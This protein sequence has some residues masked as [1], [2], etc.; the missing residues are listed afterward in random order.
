ME[1]IQFPSEEEVRAA[2]RQGEEAV[3][4]LFLQLV[5]VFGARIQALEDRLA[6]DSHNS[7]QPP[8]SDGL[9]KPAPKNLRK[10]HGRHKGGQPG[11]VGYTLKAV[12]HPDRI[13]VHRVQQ[14][15]LCGASLEQVEASGRER[16]QV[17]DLPQVQIEVT[18]HQVE[19]KRCPQC[20][21]TNRAEF[22]AGI[23][24]PVQ[25]GPEIK[26]Q[27]VYLHQ[28][29]LLPLERVSETLA[30]LYGQPLA[31]GTILAACLEAAERVQPVNAAIQTHLSQQAE[32]VH[33][34]ETG[35]RLAGKLCWLHSASTQR[36][37]YYAIHAKRGKQATDE[38]GILPRLQGWAVH[39]GW[40]SYFRYAHLRHAL[41]NAHHLRELE[42]LQERYPQAWQPK[43]A[44]LLIKIKEAV[45]AARLS[46]S[47]LT[48]EQ[49]RAFQ[50]RYKRLIAQG[51]R[52]NPLP[53]KSLEQAHQRG[54][55][56]RSP[57][58]NLLERLQEHQQAVLAYMYD[59]EVPFDN[60]QAERDLRM[61]KLKQKV[62]G[63]FRSAQGAQVFCQLRAYLSTARKN[64]QPI[65]GVLRSAFAGEP[66]WP[67]FLSSAA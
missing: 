21:E 38:I 6:K 59:F 40:K 57:P 64:R 58:R 1:P 25:Y 12:A 34:D 66:Y 42:F 47:A 39:D 67:P 60:N 7:N 43:L 33:F 46:Q 8:S 53:Q 16:R 9:N 49:L 5:E 45:S 22:P 31:Q 20:G 26:A 24:Q 13:E 54:R 17:F 28:Y 30:D 37:T 14:C 41:C 52:A 63:C 36:L 27:A 11:H 44:D 19:I 4:E 2:Y 61:A 50:R 32:V 51:L 15:H 48:P 3:V 65:L 23:T 29:Q 10:R 55:A 35:M 62:S 18:E 56:K